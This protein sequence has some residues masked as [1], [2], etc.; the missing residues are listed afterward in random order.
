MSIGR[1]F[2]LKNMN[3]VP[4][5]IIKKQFSAESKKLVNDQIFNND[6]TAHA[7]KTLFKKYIFK[8]YD[9]ILFFYQFCSSNGMMKTIT[10]IKF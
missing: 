5:C 7:T 3:N 1:P 9:D 10:L 8:E 6:E 2:F 4:S